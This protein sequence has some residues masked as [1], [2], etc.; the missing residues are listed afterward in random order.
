MRTSADTIEAVD[1]IEIAGNLRRKKFRP[2][3][4]SPF[5]AVLNRDFFVVQCAIRINVG[6][7]IHANYETRGIT[8]IDTFFALT[9][10]AN[11]MIFHTNLGW[12]SGAVNKVESS[13]WADIF[14]E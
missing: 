11:L 14:A 1:T 3:A 5:G 4:E 10:F 7:F 6:D 13:Q 8:P 12:R 9:T 2:A